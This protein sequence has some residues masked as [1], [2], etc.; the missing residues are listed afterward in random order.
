MSTTLSSSINNSTDSSI[1]PLCSQNNIT[2]YDCPATGG[3]LIT[4]LGN[5]FGGFLFV[6]LFVCLFIYFLKFQYNSI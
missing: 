6:Y 4:I 1:D 3:A 2:V 5:N